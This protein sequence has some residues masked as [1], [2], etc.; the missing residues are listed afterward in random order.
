MLTAAA[1]AGGG[2]DFRLNGEWILAT[3]GN[4][5]GKFFSTAKVDPAKL[6]GSGVV[7]VFLIGTDAP[8][9]T[10]LHDWDGFGM[11]STESQ[12]VRYTDAAGATLFGLP[13][14]IELVQPF[15]FWC[16]LFAVFPLR[17]ARAVGLGRGASR[18]AGAGAAARGGAGGGRAQRAH[19]P[20]AE[21]LAG[22]RQGP[23]DRVI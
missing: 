23:D 13:N 22:R 17:L 2:R 11:R 3:G 12:T 20:R 7:E 9:V 15:T 8:G 6:P 1:K 19:A 16:C 18:A 5:A 10:I 4:L 21:E 14:F